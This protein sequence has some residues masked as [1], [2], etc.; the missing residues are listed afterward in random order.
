MEPLPETREA[1]GEYVS[2]DEPDAEELLHSLGAL[3][4]GLVPELV[5]LSLGLVR[6][7]LTF[8]L[9]SSDARLSAL[10]G[11]QYLDGGPCV[12]VGEGDRDVASFAVDD[13]LDEERWQLFAHASAAA[14][15]G[16]TLSLPIYDRGALVG[17]VN[18]YASTADAFEGRQGE[19]SD[20]VGALPSEA[21]ANADLSFSTRLDAV[22]AP[23]RLR[24]RNDIETAVG[25][26]AGQQ[27][28]DIE[29]ARRKLQRAAARAAV[30]EAVL[31]RL[32]IVVHTGGEDL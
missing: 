30:T 2:L 23:Q 1:L 31:A 10:D 7:G 15:V 22:A 13:P 29:S 32:M 17:G 9:V 18:L 19:L 14:G 16:S 12:E 5:G 24:E 6:E 20:L 25:L 28:I 27:D 11:A 26:L 3:A 4:Q 8:T 21:V